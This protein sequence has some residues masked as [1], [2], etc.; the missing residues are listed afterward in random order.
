MNTPEFNLN[1]ITFYHSI[2]PVLNTYHA[3]DYSYLCIRFCE[4][5]FKTK[6][7]C[8]SQAECSKCMFA[9][10]FVQDLQTYILDIK[11]QGLDL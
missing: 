4:S 10:K 3:L 1:K 8:K 7:D 9:E 11:L 2:E 5:K 6:D